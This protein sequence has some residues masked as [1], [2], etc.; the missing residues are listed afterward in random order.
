MPGFHGI[1]RGRC[2]RQSGCTTSGHWE[3]QLKTLAE[4]LEIGSPA[5]LR[6]ARLAI[7]AGYLRNLTTGKGLPARYEVVEDLPEES[8][9]LPPA[10]HPRLQAFRVSPLSRQSGSVG[11]TEA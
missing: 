6:R 3:I 9:I 11:S 2:R 4:A 8:E 7:A 5:A 1:V 10:D